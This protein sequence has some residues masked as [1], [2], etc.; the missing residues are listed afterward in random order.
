MQHKILLEVESSK[1]HGQFIAREVLEGNM[2]KALEGA[3]G[4]F[5]LLENQ[6]TWYDMEVT[7]AYP[8][9][10]NPGTLEQKQRVTEA[11]R[12]AVGH[13]VPPIAYTRFIDLLE[14]RGLKVCYA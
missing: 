5:T 12:L 7:K 6:E 10:D 1:N 3:D 11:L 2:C 13:D 14:E 8:L 9:P 4:S